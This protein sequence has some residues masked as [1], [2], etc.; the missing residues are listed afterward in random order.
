MSKKCINCNH[1]NPSD[2]F[3]CEKCNFPFEETSYNK[4]VKIFLF[5]K[6]KKIPLKNKTYVIGRGDMADINISDKYMSM[7]HA[8]LKVLSSHV[9]LKDLKSKNGTF[10]DKIK[11]DDHNPIKLFKN[12]VFYCGKTKFEIKST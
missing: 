5:F 7:R 9:T 4:S 8:E 2:I 10:I 3:Y 1:L 12:N 6:E 11:I